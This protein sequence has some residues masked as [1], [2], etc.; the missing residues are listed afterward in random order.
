MKRRFKIRF[1]LGAGDNF[2]KWRIEN[3]DTGDVDFINPSEYSLRLENCK[4][5]NQKGSAEKIFE[6]SNKTVCSWIMVSKCAILT[7]CDINVSEEIIIF[8]NPRVKPYWR[9]SEGNNIDKKEF[10]TLET[11]GRMLYINKK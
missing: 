6:G 1:H 10:N 4:L 3:T 11:S 8:Y 5:Y 2:A 9:D 7:S